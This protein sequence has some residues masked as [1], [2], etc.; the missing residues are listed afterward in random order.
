[1]P[2]FPGTAGFTGCCGLLSTG[3]EVAGTFELS[4]GDACPG[5]KVRQGFVPVALP[6]E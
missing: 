4:P 5:K 2:L 6:S 1:M 3:G